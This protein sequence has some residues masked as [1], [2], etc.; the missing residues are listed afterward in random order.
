MCMYGIS[1]VHV[2]CIEKNLAMWGQPD[3]MHGGLNHATAAARL[4]LAISLMYGN[5]F[6]FHVAFASFTVPP[7]SVKSD[8]AYRSIVQHLFPIFSE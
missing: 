3:I 1:H 6:S 7:E 4:H 5:A 2:T 8:F